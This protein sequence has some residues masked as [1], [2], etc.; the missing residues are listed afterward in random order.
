MAG[1][2]ETMYAESAQA[3]FCAIADIAG[4][5]KTKKILDVNLF[6]SYNEFKRS[7][8]KII[9]LSSFK[10]LIKSES[11]GVCIFSTLKQIP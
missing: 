2:V 7:N 4:K 1:A 3:L 10:I 8:K 6:P 5:Q 11:L 9:D